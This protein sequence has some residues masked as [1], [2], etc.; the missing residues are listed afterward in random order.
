[1]NSIHGT[2]GIFTYMKSTIHV[3]K[4]TS[5]MDDMGMDLLL[6]GWKTSFENIPSLQLTA[7]APENGPRPSRNFIYE[8]GTITMLVSGRVLHKR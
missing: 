1:M 6:N 3:G 7:N 5:H 4:Y 2:N 8:P